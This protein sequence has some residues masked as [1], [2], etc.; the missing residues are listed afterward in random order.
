MAASLEYRLSGGAANSDHAAALGGAA[1]TTAAVHAGRAS[2]TVHPG[3]AINRRTSIIV[4]PI[5][6][7]PLPNIPAHII[8]PQLIGV[9]R[10]HR[11]GCFFSPKRIAFTIIF[12]I[13]GHLVNRIAA[14]VQ[15]PLTLIAT[16]SR[17]F[18]LRLGRQPVALAG[19][20]IQLLEKRLNIVPGNTLH[21][22]FVASFIM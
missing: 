18:P 12:I 4:M 9:F 17:L 7:A 8:Q 2:R 3:A 14:A 1:P 16:A 19:Q 13:P 5:I 15:V 20:G 6:C 21:R 10:T 22:A 11:P